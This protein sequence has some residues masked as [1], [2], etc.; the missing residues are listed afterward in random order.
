VADGPV[1]LVTSPLHIIT[2]SP[3]FALIVLGFA[4]IYFLALRGTSEPNVFNYLTIAFAFLVALAGIVL[5]FRRGG[6]GAIISDAGLSLSVGS[7][8]VEQAVSQLGKNYDILRKQAMQGF[9]L[10]GTF[11]GLGILVILTGSLGEMFGFTKAASNLTTVAGVIIEVVSGLGLY[12]FKE[13]FKQLNSTSEKL[14]D[15][16][17]ILAA[18]KK[19]DTL[20]DDRKTDVTI[21]LINKLVAPSTAQT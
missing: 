15:M 19:A 16:W 1:E 8:D 4:T 17:K 12:L 18:F 10:A 9:V 6:S 14:H 21:D 3:G 20:P 7:S 2:A 13:T 5:M 11:M